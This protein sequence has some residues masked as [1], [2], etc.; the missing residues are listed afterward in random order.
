[1]QFSMYVNTIREW[2]LLNVNLTIGPYRY[3][4]GLLIRKLATTL[5]I[6]LTPELLNLTFRECK[7]FGCARVTSVVATRTKLSVS[8]LFVIYVH[9]TMYRRTNLKMEEELNNDS[10]SDKDTV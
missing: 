1:M 5:F 3:G 7:G 4:W 2:I 10:E 9:C 8:L 6:M